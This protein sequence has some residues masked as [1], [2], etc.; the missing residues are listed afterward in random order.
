MMTTAKYDLRVDLQVSGQRWRI[1][2]YCQKLHLH[3]NP[4]K[5]CSVPLFGDGLDSLLLIDTDDLEIIKLRIDTY[6]NQLC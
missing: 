6:L 2:D 4:F 5:Y 3:F 1:K